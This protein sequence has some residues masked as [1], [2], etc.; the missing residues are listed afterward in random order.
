[1]ATV[2][3]ENIGKLTDKVTVTLSKQDYLPA[4]EQSIKKQAKNANI[5]G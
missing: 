5:P 2:S 4:F 3:R 1:M